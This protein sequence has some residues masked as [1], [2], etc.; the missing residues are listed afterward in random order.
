MSSYTN[1]TY[2]VPRPVLTPEQIQQQRIQ[3]A[4]KTAIRQS[5]AARK[6][7]IDNLKNQQRSREQDFER[8]IAG[9]D[10][11]TKEAAR[12]HRQQMQK[13]SDEF[14]NTLKQQETQNKENLRA[15]QEKTAE[16]LRITNQHIDEVAKSQQRQIDNINQEIVGINNRFKSEAE[17][18]KCLQKELQTALACVDI[19]QHNKYKPG[20][21]QII[22]DR[23]NGLDSL[24][25]ASIIGIVY[26]AIKDL[27]NLAKEIEKARITYE[28]KHTTTLQAAERVLLTMGENRKNTCFTD[29]NNNILEDE[30]GNPVKVEL[31][32][33]SEGEYGRLEQ[34]LAALKEKIKNGLSDP[35]FTMQEL[36]N[37]LAEISAIDERQTQIV[38]ESIMKGVASEARAVQ[39]DAAVDCLKK[40]FY[41]LVERGY[42]NGDQR[43]G[44]KV[45]MKNDSGNTIDVLISSKADDLTELN[46][47]THDESEH[48]ESDSIKLQRSKELNAIIK[49]EGIEG[50]DSSETRCIPERESKISK[51]YDQE[52]LRES[53]KM[54][55]QNN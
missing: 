5:D 46:I 10:A 35:N 52:A 8:R 11:E 44:Y 53:R 29:G 21:L 13:Q 2:R 45:K 30:S 9:L 12:R 54:S 39:A 19:L 15:L 24:P 42:E 50:M 23:V 49:N 4:V 27:N 51:I 6:R 38:V 14:Y 28:I 55:T 40:Q 37:A 17:K 31:D 18:A 25:A 33:W 32:F 7:E 26:P 41:E 43:K 34:N 1:S 16:A 48:Y 36:D 22:T 3:S 20:D 47:E